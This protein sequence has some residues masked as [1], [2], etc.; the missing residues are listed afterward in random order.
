MEIKYFDSGCDSLWRGYRR[1]REATKCE[2]KEKQ[3]ASAAQSVEVEASPSPAV[4]H[5]L[6]DFFFSY[7]FEFLASFFF[8]LLT[9]SGPGERFKRF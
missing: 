3:N 4:L 9:G 2:R 6:G 1:T 5:D 8:P 7:C